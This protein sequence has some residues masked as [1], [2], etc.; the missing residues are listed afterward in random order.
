MTE[1]SYDPSIEDLISLEYPAEAKT[2]P[3]GGTVAVRVRTT[4]WADNRYE[5]LVYLIDTGTG[6]TRQLTREGDVT[7]MEWS[8]DQDLLLLWDRGEKPQVWLLQGLTGEPVQLTDAE[9]GVE[10]FRATAGGV[11]YLAE[12]SPCSHVK[13]NY[14]EVVHFEQR[15]SA[16]TLYYLDTAL[17]LRQLGER[18]RLS[19]EEAKELPRPVIEVSRLLGAPLK[20]VGFH[21][22]GGRVYVNTRLKDPLV[23]WDTAESH[24]LTVDLEEA[25]S[26]HVRGEEWTGGHAVLGL[27]SIS[28]VEAV[29]PDGGMI[30]VSHRGRDNMMY[31]QPD[32]WL[33]GLGGI[34]PAEPLGSS[35]RKLTGGFDQW[36]GQLWWTE[37]GV[38]GWYSAGTATRIAR[39]TVEGERVEPL[40]LPAYPGPMPHVSAEGWLSYIG[41]ARDGFPEV[42]ASTAPLGEGCDVVK[43]T[44]YAEQVE[45]WNLGTV[46]TVSWR[47]RDGATVEGVLRKPRGYDPS[48]RYPLVFQVHGGPS[49]ASREYLL[50]PYDY[51]RYPPVQLCNLGVLVLKPNYRGSTGYGQAFLELNKDNLGVGD[52]WDLESAVDSLV[53][54]GVVDPGRVGCMGWS[55]GGYISAFAGMHSD[56]FSA[57]SVGA[58]ISD[59]YTYHVSNDIPYFTD[60]YL[61]AGPWENREIYHKTAPISGIDGAH[62]PTLIQHGAKDMRV[63]LINA[64]ELYRALKAKGVPV[65]MFVYPEM[66]HPITK[67]RENRAVMQQNLDW[68][69]HYI[70]GESLDYSEYDR[71]DAG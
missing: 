21:A 43:L 22:A 5:H 14:G 62:T 50:E 35:M 38:Y 66:A 27:P 48:R 2:C 13:D 24:M 55:Q 11:L 32:L 3:G 8:G 16:S 60:H 54:E 34:D 69:S 64:M 9:N 47:S 17:H 18:K 1:S 67:P 41:N 59:W 19:E 58:G 49:T 25:A 63:P 26:R 68:F 36:V 33:V 70:L 30:L 53:A 10:N 39:I 61:S 40:G 29:S 20:I 45:G 4:N 42:Y 37:V 12:R 28:I 52:L 56:K 65:E 51:Q 46:E 44:D 71:V 6:E 23:Y 31:T 7:Q 15:E 57:V